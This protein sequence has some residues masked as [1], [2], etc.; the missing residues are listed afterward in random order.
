M[1]TASTAPAT[2]GPGARSP[3]MASRAIRI[4]SLPQ[5]VN[6]CRRLAP[7]PPSAVL[8]WLL[9]HKEQT[10]ESRARNDGNHSAIGGQASASSTPLFVLKTWR[11]VGDPAQACQAPPVNRKS[12]F[13][14]PTS[15]SRATTSR[16]D[17]RPREPLI[18]PPSPAD[19]PY[20]FVVPTCPPVLPPG[21]DAPI[22]YPPTLVPLVEYDG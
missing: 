15:P 12:Q 10:P 2:I 18:V 14:T 8:P 20:G 3:P 4:I 13:R 6:F 11:I 1:R 17:L 21:P 9:P 5:T 7:D 16:R 19:S 22:P